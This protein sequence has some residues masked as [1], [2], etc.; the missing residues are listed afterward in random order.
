MKSTTLTLTSIPTRVHKSGLTLLG[1]RSVMGKE[2]I[3]FDHPVSRTTH[4]SLC[5]DAQQRKT[6]RREAVQNVGGLYR[7][8][9]LSLHS[10][11]RHGFY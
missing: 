2:H 4:H 11:L 5:A 1:T 7:E 3:S 6:L 8:V 10:P 9:P